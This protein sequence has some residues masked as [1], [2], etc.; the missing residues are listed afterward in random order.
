MNIYKNNINLIGDFFMKMEIELNDGQ[1]EKVEILKQKGV[2]VGEAIDMLFEMKEDISYQSDLLIESKISQA[3]KKKA[4]LQSQIKD[5]DAEIEMYNNLM[6]SDEDY[7]KKQKVLQK[8]LLDTE[9]YDRH[10]QN[11][12]HGFKWTKSIF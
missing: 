4:E 12:K 11:A 6:N 3:T 1:A 2:S 10:V 5:V 9:T 7:V 8:E